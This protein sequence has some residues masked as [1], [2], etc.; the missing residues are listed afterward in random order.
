MTSSE[1]KLADVQGQFTQVVKDGHKYDDVS[2][3][4]GRFLLS[5]RRLILI[6]NEGKRTIPISDIDTIGGRHDV[7]QAVATVSGYISLQIGNDVILVS[8]NDDDE[9]F[10]TALHKALLD[11]EIVLVKHPAVEGGVVTDAAWRKGRLSLDADTVNIAVDTGELV[12]IDRD[13]IGGVERTEQTVRSDTRPV[14]DVEH[15]PEETSV[16]THIS[17]TPRHCSILETV[18]EQ[19]AEQN[20]AELDLGKNEKEVLVALYSGVSPFDI[21]DFLGLPVDEVEDIY[22]RLIELDVLEEVRVRREVALKAR[23]RNIASEAM[24]DTQP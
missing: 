4:S 3:R 22:E 20:R 17:G 5:D 24:N 11:G 13:D 7:N 21:P 9:S 18:L 23:G 2:W 12:T 15:S 14:L 16:R 1:R 19:G 8:P 10:Q 6:G